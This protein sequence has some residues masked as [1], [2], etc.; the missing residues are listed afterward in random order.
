MF[1][2][3]VGL[4]IAYLLF[5]L[6]TGFLARKGRP[7]E[8]DETL[9]ASVL[10]PPMFALIATAVAADFVWGRLQGQSLRRH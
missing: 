1:Q 3:P 5:G 2:D 4:A 6:I 9:L 7:A 8:W 10:G